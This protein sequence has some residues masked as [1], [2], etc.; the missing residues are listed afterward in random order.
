MALSPGPCAIALVPQGFQRHI[1][2]MRLV[3]R[4]ALMRLVVLVLLLGVV[5]CAAWWTMIR[6]PLKSHQG[7]L[8]PLGTTE[9][10]V[11]DT[12]RQDVQTL[13][14]DI[15]ERNVSTPGQLR[16][17]ARFIENSFQQA[18]YAVR[19][20]DFKVH[21][22]TCQNIEASI[23]G[24]TLPHD[25]VLV[26]A[27]YDTVPNSPG[28]ND[29]GSG[30]AALLALA[31]ART[32]SAPGRT[33]RFVAFVNEE[34]PYFQTDE[35]GS[36][37]YAKACRAR[38]DH[39]VAMLSLETMGYYDSAPGS[40]RYPFPMGL[41]YPSRGDF[42]AFVSNTANASL[43]RQCI[44]TFRSHVA[45]PSEGGALPGLLPGVGWSDHWAFWQADYPA[46][47]ITDTAPFRYPH[48]HL[49]SDT[50]DKLDYDRLARLTIGL[51]AVL[52][53]LVNP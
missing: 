42:I 53:S 39:I 17:A 36:V 14:G 32:G 4:P 24:H 18:G 6:M 13:A 51:N 12:L 50:P 45:F 31:R 3:T 19:H 2:A 27:H 37:V 1:Q 38:G 7:P 52:E 44:K 47:M 9:I 21:D 28:A 48:Y 16:A 41:F 30:I 49:D 34:P 20:Q 40:Q 25:I 26:G 46:V 8:P 5:T 35:M 22:V 11:R 10:A 15:G 43:V 33:V 29:N 23:Q